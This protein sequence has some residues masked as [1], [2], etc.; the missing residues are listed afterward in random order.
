[1]SFGRD[2]DGGV[3]NQIF[4]FMVVIF[5]A[6][7]ALSLGLYFGISWLVDHVRLVVIK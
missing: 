1:M 2:M 5:L 4:W 6:G 3:A 7:A